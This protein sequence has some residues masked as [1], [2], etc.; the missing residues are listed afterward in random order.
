MSLLFRMKQTSVETI[1]VSTRCDGSGLPI[2]AVDNLRFS[3]VL[4]SVSAVFSS[5]DMTDM[6]DYPWIGKYFRLVEVTLP[7]DKS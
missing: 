5:D 4:E 3:V 6:P 1:G 7:D 2:E